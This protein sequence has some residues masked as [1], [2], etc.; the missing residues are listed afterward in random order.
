M[1]ALF[2][3]KSH[4]PRKS[5]LYSEN[6]KNTLCSD[7]LISD[8]A[9]YLDTKFFTSFWLVAFPKSLFCM[10]WG[11]GLPVCLRVGAGC[12]MEAVAPP[13]GEEAVQ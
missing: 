10:I 1:A 9:Y 4:D 11:V 8:F 3:S 2:L 12:S 13:C 7:V 5:A 6:V